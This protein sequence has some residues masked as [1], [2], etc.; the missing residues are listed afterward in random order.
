MTPL[1]PVQRIHLDLLRLAWGQRAEAIIADL[2]ACRPLWAAVLGGRIYG[3]GGGELIPLRDLP[4]GIWNVD[5]IYVLVEG[6]PEHQARA[7][8]AL[9]ALA[10]P[11]GAMF[12][13][14]AADTPGLQGEQLARLL[15][16]S[17]PD[18]AR[19]WFDD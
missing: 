11:W 5:T 3:V 13:W 14:Y 4:Q 19:F 18:L 12:N 9:A 8:A 1:S 17:E 7:H 16:T 10:D 15:G 6:D 2:L